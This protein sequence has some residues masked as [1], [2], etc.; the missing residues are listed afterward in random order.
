MLTLRA[1]KGPDYYERPEFARDDYYAEMEGRPSAAPG[2][3][4]I[5]IAK[6]REGEPGRVYATANLAYARIDDREDQDVVIE[7]NTKAQ[8]NAGGFR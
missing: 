1:A 4:E 5:N 6:H 3:V 2:I 8:K 7:W